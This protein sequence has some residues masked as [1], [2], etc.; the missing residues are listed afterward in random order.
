MNPW[1]LTMIVRQSMAPW[2]RDWGTT[3][4]EKQKIVL[5]LEK[6]RI[7]NI[8][9]WVL[10]CYNMSI[11]VNHNI[12]TWSS[13]KRYLLPGKILSTEVVHNELLSES[14]AKFT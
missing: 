6:K 1:M 14:T 4:R 13:Q 11:T 3:F 10:Y 7:Q 9:A 8:L 2:F 12:Q 5:L